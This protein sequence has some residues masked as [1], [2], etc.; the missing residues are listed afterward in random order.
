VDGDMVAGWDGA[1]QFA[2]RPPEILFQDR[3]GN[4]GD[5]VLVAAVGTA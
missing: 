2:Q 5:A 4:G 1:G 3:R